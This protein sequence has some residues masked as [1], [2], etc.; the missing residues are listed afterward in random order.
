MENAHT[1]SLC[2]ETQASLWTAWEFSA[3]TTQNAI[4]KPTLRQHEVARLT[5]VLPKPQNRAY[6]TLENKQIAK[7]VLKKTLYDHIFFL[8]IF[9][10]WK[11]RRTKYAQ[12]ALVNWSAVLTFRCGLCYLG[13]EHLRSPR[14][15]L[16][17]TSTETGMY[18]C[19]RSDFS[20]SNPD[21][22]VLG[23][24]TDRRLRDILRQNIQSTPKQKFIAVHIKVWFTF[25]DMYHFSV[26]SWI[27]FQGH[28]S[29]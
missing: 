20:C 10:C 9:V 26:K 27:Y 4:Q 7:H 5:H 1:V 29:F 16:L 8:C 13:V 19:S 17:A 6:S 12:L 23:L 22:P 24:D 3:K 25:H 18:L 2:R 11:F 21:T 14:A 28:A 15:N